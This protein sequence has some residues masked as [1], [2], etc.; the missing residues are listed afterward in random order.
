MFLKS[1][2]LILL[3]ALVGLICATKTVASK[4]KNVLFFAIDDLRPELGTYGIDFVKSPNIDKLASQSILFERAYCQVAICAPSRTSLLTGR[5]PDTNHVWEVS[6]DEYWRKFTNATTIP[7][8]FKENGYISAGMGKIFHPGAPSGNDDRAYSW[9]V[10]YFH[11]PSDSG[12]HTSWHSFDTDDSNLWDGKIATNA[13]STLNEI[14]QNRSKGDNRPFFVA[15]GFHKPHL[16]WYCAK[17]YY[18][19]Y[20]PAEQIAPPKNPNVP[21]DFPP[22][23][24]GLSSI[25]R[26][27]DTKEFFPNMTKCETDVQASLYGDECR[28][29]ENYTKVLRRAYYSCVSYTDAQVGRV[30]SALESM[31]F[32]EDTI[33]VL[34]GDHGWHLG[35]L[36]HWTKY[37]NFEDSAR[38]PFM[39]KVP[40]VTDGGIRTKALVELI[41]IFPTLTE[42]AGL[43]VPPLCPADSSKKQPL[44]C[45]E[46]TS[47]TPLLHDPKK[48]WKKAAFSQ[49]VRPY[50]GMT[51][52]PDEPAFKASEHKESVMGYTIRVDQYRFIEWYRFNCTTAIPNFTDIWGTELY[53]HTKPTVFFDD[54]NVNMANQPEMQDLVKSLRKMLQAG[55]RA[56]LP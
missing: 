43:P 41:D 46:G 36:N 32:A 19:M 53:N 54:E 14:K 31:G 4:K 8:Y 5:R 1:V 34:W 45:V 48:E 52:I 44:V 22:I 3:V 15:V 55:W 23:A 9:N 13:V 10:P 30:I 11:A 50:F 6:G 40:G 18:D 42:L 35:E 33:I 17:K 7:Q 56:V 47:L 25:G 51:S 39:L 37:T 24:R 27:V 26:F 12:N 28:I 38:V 16:P 49:F 20:P 21:K 2:L 29:P